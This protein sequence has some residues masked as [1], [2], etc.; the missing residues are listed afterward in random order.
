MSLGGCENRWILSGFDYRRFL[1]QVK[2]KKQRKAKALTKE[3]IENDDASSGD[4]NTNVSAV[5]SLLASTQNLK[6]VPKIKTTAEAKKSDEEEEGKD[7]DKKKKHKESKD[8]KE[9]K[10]KK[11]KVKKKKKEQGPMHFTANNEPVSLEIL[12]DL[13]PTIFKEVCCSNLVYVA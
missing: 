11:E 7:E 2:P 10:E 9:K 8:K 6:K 13:D 5:P 1:S 3:I 4:D 12:G